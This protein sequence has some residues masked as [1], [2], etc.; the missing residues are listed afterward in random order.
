MWNCY[1]W[2]TCYRQV[3][4]DN[5]FGS[6]MDFRFSFRVCVCVCVSMS[7]VVSSPKSS[8]KQPLT[9]NPKDKTKCVER[10][11]RWWD[12]LNNT[13][14]TQQIKRTQNQHIHR[15]WNEQ[16]EKIDNM[17]INEWCGRRSYG[18]TRKRARASAY[19]ACV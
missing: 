14:E 1:V 10:V 13:K 8:Q 19:S 15:I 4:K 9:K 17:H 7:S 11:Y 6:R 16:K 18:W 5:N 2:Q 3:H 12:T